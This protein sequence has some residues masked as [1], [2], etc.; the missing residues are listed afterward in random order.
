MEKN[1][2]NDLFPP[3]G[4]DEPPEPSPEP[5]AH[6]TQVAELKAQ[7]ASQD[8]KFQKQNDDFM[9]MLAARP[10]TPQQIV[11]NPA[12]APQEQPIPDVLEDPDG[13]AR[14]VTE[15]AQRDAQRIVTEQ[16]QQLTNKYAE[17]K[18][19]ER[20]YGK[21]KQIDAKVA[22]DNAELVEFIA[23][24]KVKAAA[25]Q[26]IDV[27]SYIFA[28]EDRFAKEVMD[29]AKQQLGLTKIDDN[30]RTAGLV[31]ENKLPTQQSA[32]KKDEGQGFMDSMKQLRYRGR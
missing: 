26:G 24:K 15:K 4:G 25:A 9:K 6:E 10:Q 18:K 19:Y 14:A 13:F 1:I 27:N 30:D 21:F 7:I 22:T 11:N 3:I 8:E 28:D 32:P 20:V 5:S 12:P 2:Q 31:T 17:D 16:T 29:E 23:V